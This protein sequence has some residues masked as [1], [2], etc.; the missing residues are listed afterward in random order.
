MI[1]HLT[2]RSK[3]ELQNMFDTLS[4][5]GK[6]DFAI[7]LQDLEKVEESIKFGAYIKHLDVESIAFKT[8]FSIKI[9][10]L[11][12]KNGMNIHYQEDLLL[13]FAAN[14]GNIELVKILLKMG[15][16]IHAR[17][18][19]SYCWAVQNGHEEVAKI[20]IKAGASNKGKNLYNIQ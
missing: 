12:L 17:K 20:L 3:K 13:R 15:A 11:L 19:T 8:N 10:A 7:E 14:D 1:K 18:D 16:N 5:N 9:I 4:P 6:L 2:P